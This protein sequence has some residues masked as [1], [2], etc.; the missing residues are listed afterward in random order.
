MAHFN[1]RRDDTSSFEYIEAYPINPKTP[2]QKKLWRNIAIGVTTLIII[3]IV[4]VVAVVVTNQKKSSSPTSGN[5]QYPISS[6]AHMTQ[7]VTD[8]TTQDK[9]RIFVVGDVH[10]CLKELN[11][12][13]T[14]IKFD[15]TKD[16]MILAGDLTTKG[17]DTVGVI[18]RAKELGL[19]CVR[20]NH[21]DKIVRLKAF[22]LERGRNA[23][24]PLDANMPEGRV[25]D[26]IKFK[27]Y[28]VAVSTQL[29][30]SDFDYLSS[31]PVILHIP[32]LNNTVVVH[33]GLDPNIDSLQDQV[34][35]LAMNMRDIDTK[36]QPNP[37]SG[38]G[39]AWA[40]AWNAKVKTSS[41]E[42][43]NIYYG[44]DAGRGLN[45]QKNTFGLDS[46]CVYGDYLTA[47][48]IKTRQRTQVKCVNYDKKSGDI[49][50]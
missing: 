26:P 10:G 14:Q 20:G 12:L 21:D 47:F 48:E 13:L 32:N 4:I 17:P 49:D 23:M 37:L 29:T 45:L 40:T 22:E 35:Y 27:N 41:T 43:M 28:H 18:R 2:K 39:T 8:T 16:Q 15:P 44:H 25:P 9:E 33:A 30:Q 38:S 6:Y 50:D 19:L 7:L 1:N 3:V 24:Y 11:T 42:N 34:P 46:G 31:C 5:S 36:N